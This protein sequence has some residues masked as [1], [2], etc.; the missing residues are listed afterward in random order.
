MI[1]CLNEVLNGREG[2]YL[3]PFF[4]WHGEPEEMLKEY[5]DK[6]W[7]SGCKAFCV[8]SRPHVQPG[9]GENPYPGY[10]GPEWWKAMDTILEAAELRGMKVWILDDAHFPTGYANGA[11]VHADPALCRQYLGF[12]RNDICGP[13]PSATLDVDTILKY[14][15]MEEQPHDAGYEPRRFLDDQVLAVVAGRVGRSNCIDRLIDLTPL[16]KEGK[17]CWDVPAGYYKVFVLFL[18][19]NG[20]GRTDYINILDR[21]SCRLQIDAAYEPHYEH[22]GHL[23]GKTIAGF[24]SDEPLIGNTSTFYFDESIGRKMMLLPWCDAMPKELEQRLG[25]DWRITLPLLWEKHEEDRE[26]AHVRV[27]FMD[28]VTRLIEKNF[29]YQLGDWC[30]GH[31][32]EYIGHIIEDNDQHSRL[33]CTLGHYFRALSGQDMA[34]I[35]NIGGQILP[36]GEDVTRTACFGSAG[37]GEFYHFVLGKLASSLAHI[38][39]KK[40]GRA[41]C[42]NFGAYGWGEGIRE[43]KYMADHFLVRGINRFVP[44]AFSPKAYP[45]PDCPPHFYAHGNNPQFR[46]FGELTGYMNRVCHLLEH[47]V[48]CAPAAVLYHGEAEW[49]GEYMADKKPARVLHE[50]QIDF[51]F[52]PSDLFQ[53][54]EIFR[55][56]FDGRLCVGEETYE[57]LV[58]PYSQFL[59]GAVARFVR[60]ASEAGFPV[61][62][63]EA[64]PLGISDCLNPEEEQELLKG[65]SGCT[66]LSLDRLAE[67]VRGTA[68]CDFSI[69]PAFRRL[70]YYHCRCENKE[71]YLILNEDP[72]ETYEGIVKLPVQ[73]SAV[74][75]DPCLNRTI[76]AENRADESGMEV[77][78]RLFPLQ[79]LVLLADPSQTVKENFEE[80]VKEEFR[81]ISGTWSVAIAR[82]REYPAFHDE[83]HMERLESIAALYPDFS[84]FIRYEITFSLSAEESFADYLELEDCYEGAEIWVNG[85]NAGMRMAK[86]YRFPV[87]ELFKEG[88]NQLRIEVASSLA[89]ENRASIE[90]MVKGN[91]GATKFFAPTGVIGEVRLVYC[92]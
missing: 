80:G 53:D 18:T 83:I 71:I 90:R 32:V 2:N 74:F 35:D 28:A 55:G 63:L 23:F 24:F 37:D 19:R 45:D 59:T 36:G 91:R 62:I 5:V 66:V 81:K 41:M 26:A 67:A 52:V 1:Q 57:T 65:L 7:E 20:G 76:E 34:G 6:I 47:A 22:Y 40:K 79:M 84:G 77:R 82:S 8:E 64:L 16:L 17:L 70:R 42:E 11:V 21:R 92:Q 72:S 60:M 33:G 56:R 51:D 25:Q 43:M 50:N 31:G 39:P 85:E 87:R 88:E 89:R 13:M 10:C 86:P 68:E 44:H 49:A 12:L 54:M 15:L 78:L 30:R 61:F 69:V 27:A 9:P 4:W 46:Y 29:S 38:D 75:Y 48:H 3:L 73:G 58:I 14:R